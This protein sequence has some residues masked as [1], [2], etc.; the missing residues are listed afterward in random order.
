MNKPLLDHGYIRHVETWGSDERIIEAARMST[1]KGV[2]GMGTDTVFQVLPRRSA[3][4]S[5]HLQSCRMFGVS[6]CKYRSRR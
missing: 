3:G 5:S 1:E 6:W 2:S 4:G